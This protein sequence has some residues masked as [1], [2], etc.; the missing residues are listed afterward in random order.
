MTDGQVFFVDDEEPLRDAVKQG[1]ELCGHPVTCF[2]SA[3][4]AEAQLGRNLYG[5]LVSDIKMPDMDGLAL[6]RRALEI[7]PALP[8]V[9]VTGHG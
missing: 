1:L 2:S 6:L 4:Q 3:R 8:V 7:D 5:V 9:L